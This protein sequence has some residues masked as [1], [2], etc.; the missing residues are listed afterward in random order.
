MFSNSAGVVSRPG[1][2]TGKVNSRR[3]GLG[4][5][6]I[7]PAAYNPFCSRMAIATSLTVNPF[8]TRRSGFNET[9]IE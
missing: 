2:S 1:A 5:P 8:M 6:P 3:F 7:S 4:L 9:R